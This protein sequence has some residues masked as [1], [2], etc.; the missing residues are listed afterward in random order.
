M[1]NVVFPPKK[2][3]KKR[4]KIA[5]LKIISVGGEVRPEK[6]WCCVWFLGAMG[7]GGGWVEGRKSSEG[8]GGTHTYVQIVLAGSV[9][10]YLPTKRLSS[11]K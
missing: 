6:D 2:I 1:G 9:V 7:V 5:P 8:G 11:E 3:S 10:D 4:T